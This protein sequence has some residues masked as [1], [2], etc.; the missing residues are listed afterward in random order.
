M[1]TSKLVVLDRTIHD[2]EDRTKALNVMIQLLNSDQQK[3]LVDVMLQ[4]ML[5]IR[6]EVGK[7]R[8]A[9][10]EKRI[11]EVVKEG[12]P[13]RAHFLTTFVN[14]LAVRADLGAGRG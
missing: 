6:E 12:A 9:V 13:S 8:L 3:A 2:I 4:I 14:M 7:L 10:N 11:D 5:D 1:S